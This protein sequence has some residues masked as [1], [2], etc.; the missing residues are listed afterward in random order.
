M[1]SDFEMHQPSERRADPALDDNDQ[2]SSS[3]H[4]RRAQNQN[5][6]QNQS[7][8]GGQGAGATPTA[9]D[10]Q[11]ANHA[12]KDHTESSVGKEVA[13]CSG[14]D[15]TGDDEEGTEVGMEGEIIDDDGRALV[16][17]P[18]ACRE[19]KVVKRLPFTRDN[20]ETVIVE[21]S[22]GDLIDIDK[23][24]STKMSLIIRKKVGTF[25]SFIEPPPSRLIF[26]VI[27]LPATSN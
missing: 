19:V 4:H 7:H 8:V 10:N 27:H 13:R 6:N 17:D 11:C 14:N 12:A 25:I 15:E 2:S 20:A 26:L 5:H 3:T 1:R 18:D 23:N 22:D 16:V 21:T 24:V 9:S